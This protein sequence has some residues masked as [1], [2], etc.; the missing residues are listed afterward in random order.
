L[1]PGADENARDQPIALIAAELEN[2]R[3][4]KIHLPRDGLAQFD[5]LPHGGSH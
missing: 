5:L 4:G 3:L 2:I 1:Q